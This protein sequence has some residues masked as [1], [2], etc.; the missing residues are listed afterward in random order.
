MQKELPNGRANRRLAGGEWRWVSAQ[1][2]GRNDNVEGSFG[3]RFPS[4]R[5]RREREGVVPV[6]HV[7]DGLSMAH[8]S[9][10]T[11]AWRWPPLLHANDGGGGGG[12]S[13][14][15]KEWHEPEA[16]WAALFTTQPVKN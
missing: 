12:L 1:R 14:V 16:V 2:W 10:G 6:P 5:R 3:R 7:D 4:Y 9:D 11:T 8:R 15:F 13:R